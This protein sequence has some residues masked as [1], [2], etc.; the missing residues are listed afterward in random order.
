MRIY[1]SRPEVLDASLQFSSVSPLPYLYSL[2]STSTFIMFSKIIAAFLLPALAAAQNYGG[3]PP[4]PVSTAAPPTPSAPPSGNGTMNVDVGFNGN[5]VFNPANITAPVGTIVNF[6]FPASLAH[7]VTQSS[8]AAP[9]TYLAA[10]NTTNP[11]TPAGFDSGLVISSIFSINVTDTQPIWFH[12]TQVTHCGLGMVGSINAP[13][14][15]N[16]TFMAFQAAAMA[17]GSNTPS[18]TG[19]GVIGGAHGVATA[20]PSSDVGGSSGS[21]SSGATRYGVSAAAALLSAAFAAAF[22]F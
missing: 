6:F 1:L 15:G 5:F 7:S 18:Q 9:C 14:T 2:L 22:M 10:D 13:T 4:A 21:N 16:N 17:L 20:L 12:C 11:P 8:F 19:P 3:P